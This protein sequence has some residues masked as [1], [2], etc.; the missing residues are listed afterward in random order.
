MNTP[1]LGDDPVKVLSALLE[2][3]YP[4]PVDV[5]EDDLARRLGLERHPR[6]ALA[7]WRELRVSFLSATLD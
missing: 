3:E 5:F 6:L 7:T 1:L 4:E 2:Q